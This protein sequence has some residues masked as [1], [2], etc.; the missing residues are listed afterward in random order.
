[1]KKIDKDGLS[2]CAIQ[3]NVFVSSL[4]YTDCS[5]EIFIRRF[6]LSQVVKEFDSSAILDDSLT[7][8]NVFQ[9]IEDEFGKSDYGKKRYGKEVL[10]W[11]GYIYR[12]FAYTYE[13]SSKYIYKI[14]KPKELNELYHV[15]H[16]FDPSI[17][18]ERILE[19]KDISFN[20]DDQNER[21]LK[22]IKN[23]HY[24][25]EIELIKITKES[26]HALFEDFKNKQEECIL[27][28]ILYKQE[29]IG[30]T[31]LKQI[32]DNK[33]EIEI[34]LKDDSY[35][36][37]GIET[38]LIKKL[39]IFADNELKAKLLVVKILKDNEDS[40]CVFKN[41]GFVYFKE[42]NDYAYYEKKL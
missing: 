18:I 26:V 38:V 23:R 11:I 40:I 42:D 39:I 10:Y 25:K 8:L 1:M 12:Y 20:I 35:K 34:N 22:L 5:S 15:Y 6:M 7:E 16:T 36:N 14:I 13:L 21:L 32:G 4:K 41:L 24:E 19:E 31:C 33:Y 3:G 17:A 29:P 37:K 2:L 9:R 30:E 27:L 28:A